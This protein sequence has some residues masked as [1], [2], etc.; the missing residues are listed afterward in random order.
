VYIGKTPTVGNFQVCDAISVVNGQAAYTLQVGG[1]NFAPESA[2]HMLVSLNGVLQKPGSSYTISGS[3][4]TFASNLATGDSIDF[5]QIL[6]NVLDIGTPSDN[7]IATAKIVDD[8][9]TAAKINDDIISG[10]TALAATPADTDELLVSDA[11]TL[12]R[13]DY[14]LIKS[15]KQIV[16]QNY[17]T[18]TNVS[19]TSYA[20]TNITADI[21]PASTANK[22][23]VIA[24]PNSDGYVNVST[25]RQFFL[26]L[27]RDSTELMNKQIHIGADKNPTNDYVYGSIDGT[28]VYLDSPSSTSALTY[29]LQAKVSST[30]NNCN[31]RIN[32]DNSAGGAESTL[33]L[34]EVSV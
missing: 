11:G 22:V 10:T 21:T 9:I 7:T 27:L 1:V 13:V 31:V 23:L 6:G 34:I 24:S 26:R 12:K 18:E 3:T 20:D 33:T 25:Y 16:V 4:L 2:N 17:G 14:S 29:K 19:N 15:I 32:G 5:I 30:A 28:M 8:A